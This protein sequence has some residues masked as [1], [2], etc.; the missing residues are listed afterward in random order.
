[1]GRE[2]FFFVENGQRASCLICHD[3]IASI[4]QYNIHLHYEET[5]LSTQTQNVGKLRA[6]KFKVMKQGLGSQRNL[7]MIKI[8]KHEYHSCKLQNSK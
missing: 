4:K 3:N 6:E 8:F 7:L 2:T 1:M 5:Q